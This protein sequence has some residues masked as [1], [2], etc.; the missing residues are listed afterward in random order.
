MW[1]CGCAT[2]YLPSSRDSRDKPAEYF[3]WQALT[4]GGW[5]PNQQ[6]ENGRMD[7]PLKF[8]SSPY[9]RNPAHASF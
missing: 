5:F 7:R 6:I 9:P 1:K 8:D 4:L 3:L 2:V